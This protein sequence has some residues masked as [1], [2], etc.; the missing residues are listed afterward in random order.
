MQND[1]ASLLAN[2]TTYEVDMAYKRVKDKDMKEVVFASFFPD[3]GRGKKYL[4]DIYQISNSKPI[5]SSNTLPCIYY[6]RHKGRLSSLV[7]PCL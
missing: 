4:P 6:T 1:Q 7:R 5:F 2:A 3:I